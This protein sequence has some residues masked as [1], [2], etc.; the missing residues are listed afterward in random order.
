MKNILLIVAD[1]AR[2]EKTVLD[3]P[4]GSPRTRCSARL[5]FLHLSAWL[6]AHPT[7]LLG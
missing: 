6:L 1:C 2:S 3:L 4:Q 7:A 5:P